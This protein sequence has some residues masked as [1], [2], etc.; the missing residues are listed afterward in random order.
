MAWN[1]W[2]NAH[3]GKAVQPPEMGATNYPIV[4]D[5]PGEYVLQRC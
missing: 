3:S 2:L 4:C 1:N 5:A